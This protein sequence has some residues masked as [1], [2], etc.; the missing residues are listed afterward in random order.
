MTALDQAGNIATGYTG[1]VHFTKSDTN[2][3]AAVPADYTFVGSDNGVHVF[4][5]GVTLASG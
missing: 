3:S 1:K 2:A 5:G 4:T